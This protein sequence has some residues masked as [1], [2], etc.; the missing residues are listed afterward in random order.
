VSEHPDSSCCPL[1]HEAVELLGRRWTGAIVDVLLEAG[2]L[3]FGEIAAAVPDLSDRLL[4]ERLKDLERRGVLVRSADPGP[5]P[6][7]RYALTPMGEGLRPAVAALKA[8]GRAWLDTS[9]P[10]FRRA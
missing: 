4:S 1:Y 3:R 10:T 8:W 6:C 9:A 5:P 7:V 2:P